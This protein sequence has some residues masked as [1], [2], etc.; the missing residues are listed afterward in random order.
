[1][2]SDLLKK[3]SVDDFS[4][5]T[6]DTIS[7]RLKSIQSSEPIVSVVIAA[8][9]E[10]TNVIRCL[11]SFANTKTNYPFEIVV[12]DNNSTDRT[13]EVLKKLNVKYVFQKIQ[14][15]GIS[16]QLGMEQA[17]GKYI[18]TG[19]ADTLY[20]PQ[21]VNEMMNQLTKPGVVCVYGRYSFISDE[22]TPRW[23]LTLY[24]SFSDLFVLIKAFKRPFLNAYGMTMGYVREYALNVGYVDA[25]IRGE[26]GRLAFDLMKFGKIK[27]V[28]SN[29]SRVWT[30]TRT[31]SQDGSLFSAFKNRLV[32]ALA[33]LGSLFSKQADHD[34]KTSSNSSADMKE[35]LKTIKKNFGLGK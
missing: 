21:W 11:D 19:D 24:E 34:T 1:M 8:Y 33:N 23:K 20:P 7:H 14:G 22:K 9:N 29:K 12:V 28:L 30:G 16:R 3:T 35:N 32:M 10:E 6:L 15:C 13:A 31:I 18:L 27:G 5:T 2:N 17:K 26:D 4:P 25:H